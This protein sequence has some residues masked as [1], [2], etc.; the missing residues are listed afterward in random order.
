MMQSPM[1]AIIEKTIKRST[2]IYLHFVFDII[3]EMNKVCMQ[4]RKQ[5]RAANRFCW[6]E[7]KTNEI[8]AI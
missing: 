2:R 4:E 3:Q 1:K 6:R 5:T 8:T 7:L